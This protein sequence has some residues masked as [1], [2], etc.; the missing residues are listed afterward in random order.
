MGIPTCIEYKAA[1]LGEVLWWTD[2]DYAN[3][4]NS[5]LTELRVHL[6]F[7]N[8][9]P[10]TALKRLYQPDHMLHD[11]DNKN[12]NN[13]ILD[14]NGN[15]N[16]TM[17]RNSYSSIGSNGTSNGDHDVGR[18]SDDGKN[19]MKSSTETLTSKSCAS[20]SSDGLDSLDYED[21]SHHSNINDPNFDY[22]NRSNGGKLQQKQHSTYNDKIKNKKN[23][24]GIHNS[25]NDNNNTNNNKN[26]GPK[27][28]NRNSGDS[29]HGNYSNDSAYSNNSSI[30]SNS[31]ALVNKFGQK[32]FPSTATINDEHRK[33]TLSFR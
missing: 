24:D 15:L 16:N 23:M 7:E 11:L 26:N 18:G 2:N 13:N 21:I 3:F 29:N 33:I 14:S 27:S 8:V 4:K 19:G 22:D 9:D 25:N 20:F 28:V 10:K 1:G 30:N 5:A 31:H 12:N 6:S 32:V 17:N